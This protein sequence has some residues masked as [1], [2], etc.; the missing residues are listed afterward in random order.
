M[1]PILKLVLLEQNNN[2]YSWLKNNE[3]I[4]PYIEY[5]FIK[6]ARIKSVN[7]TESLQRVERLN[8]I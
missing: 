6:S 7:E 3:F 1:D 5:F 4:E 2:K 8:A